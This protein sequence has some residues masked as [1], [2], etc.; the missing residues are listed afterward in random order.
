MRQVTQWSP[1]TC[2]CIL[3]YEWDDTVPA[4]QRSHTVVEVVK[5]CKAHEKETKI[6]DCYTKVKAENQLKNITLKQIL[7]DLPADLK[8]TVVNSDGV[9]VDD[10]KKE[11]TWSFDED[12]K[13]HVKIEGL[14]E[15]DKLACELFLDKD[16][17][18]LD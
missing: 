13:L 10:Y 14:K 8:K 7:D 18:V 16:K 3:K 17:I 12:R 4:E 11:P 6:T 15:E 9:S 5:K 2:G 1:D